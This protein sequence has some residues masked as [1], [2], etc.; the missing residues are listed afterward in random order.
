MMRSAML[1][2]LLLSMPALVEARIYQYVDD[3][4][5][6][7]FVDQLSKV[8]ARYRNQ[9]ETREEEHDRLAP[10]ELQALDQQRQL[11]DWQQQL[12]YNREQIKAAMQD[13]ITP[14]GMHHS[15]ITVPVKVVYGSRS[16]YLTLVMDTGATSTVLHK[17][18]ISSLGA[19]YLPSGY[20]R[21]ADGR[22]VKTEAI[23]L[24]RIEVGPY[25][26]KNVRAGIIDFQGGSQDTN[27]LLGM[28]FLYHARYE[29]D[30]DNQQIIWEPEKYQSLQDELKRLDEIEAEMLARQQGDGDKPQ[31]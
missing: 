5:R 17:G 4:G 11:K 25:K 7:V 14:I 1:I 10:G 19:Q 28:D 15:R 29:I 2:C 18:A 8:P 13:W 21:V 24:D 26:I 20:A 9:L 31:K 3:T 27:G 6:K 30:R 12:S 22:R 16:Q 23:N